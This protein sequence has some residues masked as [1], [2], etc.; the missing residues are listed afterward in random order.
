LS[1]ASSGHSPAISQSRATLFVALGAC[2]F[3]AISIFVQL[4]TDAG[5]P[6][7]GVLAWRYAI[8]A[9]VLLGVLLYGGRRPDGRG[10][11]A[12]M[13]AGLMQ[14][15]IAVVSLSAL[16]YIT[17]GTL[18]F[19]FYTYPALVAILA[20]IRHSEP[21]STTRMIALALSL[22]GIF[23]MI[24]APGSESLH[25]TGIILALVSAGMYAVYIPMISTLQRELTPVAT[26]M[27]MAAG[28]AV[29]L[30]VAAMSQG[31]LSPHY[32][33]IGWGSILALAVLCTAGAFFV[34]LRGLSVLGPV[35]TA[36]VSTVEPFFTAILG[37][38]FL[39]QP[40]TPTVL[41]GGALIAA[42]VV[43]LQRGANGKATSGS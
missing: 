32:P 41:A 24:G 25:P 9:L 38:L 1:S 30:G 4:A 12:M 37:A 7:L 28:A 5:T 42:A 13:T 18:A 21:L 23:V 15:L 27:Y 6:L 2:G 40:M 36:I 17:A 8:A 20:R 14:S 39:N 34:F 33:A 16:R 26:A 43:L 29:F 35:R 11:K 31:E 22:G 3:G 19:L 10:F